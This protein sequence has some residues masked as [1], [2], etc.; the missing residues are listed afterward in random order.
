MRESSFWQQIKSHLPV[1]CHAHRVENGINSGTPDVELCY[2]GTTAW[3]ELKYLPAYPKRATTPIRV[4]H[5]TSEQITWLQ[6]RVAAGGNGW[7][8]VRVVDDYYLFHPRELDDLKEGRNKEWWKMNCEA[9]WINRM[10]D[11]D[12][13]EWLRTVLSQP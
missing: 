13:R 5:L 11:V 3:I 12:W 9:C 7:L 6:R 2:R 8:F 10:I 4:D 1:S